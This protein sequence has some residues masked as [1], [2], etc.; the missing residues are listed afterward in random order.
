MKKSCA[1]ASGIKES[2][3]SLTDWVENTLIY[4]AIA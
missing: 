3:E 1:E 4:V 2:E